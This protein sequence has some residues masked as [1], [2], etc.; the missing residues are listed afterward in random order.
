MLIYM[1]DNFSKV[2]LKGCSWNNLSQPEFFQWSHFYL[3]C[4]SWRLIS[5][6]CQP[7]WSCMYWFCLH[8]LG[9]VLLHQSASVAMYFFRTSA[10]AIIICL[11]GNIKVFLWSSLCLPYLFPWRVLLLLHYFILFPH[12]FTYVSGMVLKSL[13]YQ[14]MPRCFG[15]H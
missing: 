4:P 14:A 8:K 10:W 7:F 2:H 13:L 3:I 6:F 12:I 5:K 11:L 9:H 15:G 1:P